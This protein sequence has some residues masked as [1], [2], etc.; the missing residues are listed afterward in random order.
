MNEANEAAGWLDP[1]I[2]PPMIDEDIGLGDRASH[3]VL[4]LNA[5]LDLR[6]VHL[7]R[8]YSACTGTLFRVWEDEDGR[9]IDVIGWIPIPE[10]KD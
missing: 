10:W 3:V 5:C 2:D 9:N 1:R 4:A 7:V 6:I 8:G